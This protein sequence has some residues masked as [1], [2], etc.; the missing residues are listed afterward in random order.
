MKKYLLLAFFSLLLSFSACNY[1][2]SD[3][4]TGVTNIELNISNLKTLPDSL[5]YV[6][7][8]LSNSDSSI[9]VFESNAD[10]NGVIRVSTTNDFNGLHKA[11][12]F[13]ITVEKALAIPDSLPNSGSSVVLE[14]RFTLGSANLQVGIG[15]SISSSTGSFS[16]T[17]P[18]DTLDNDLS[19]VWFADSLMREGGPL[20]G[21]NLPVLN[22]GWFYEGIV[23][24]NNDT[25]ST[26][27][28]TD[29]DAADEF[30]GYSGTAAGLP[31]PGED[32]LFNPKPGFTFPLD[33]SNAQ[34]KILL[35]Y[36]SPLT[37]YLFELFEGTIP[38]GVQ[39]NTTHQL[40][41]IDA[42]VPTG[43]VSIKVDIVE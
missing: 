24:I 37:S 9:K 17:T 22:T 23:L 15:K 4:P 27:E 21:F 29:P 13:W 16:I 8:I 18:T 2:E 19:G 5:I 33:L 12:R 42:P 43:V 25:L 34:V 10:A 36:E 35:R 11:Q 1:F 3:N 28:F 32:F 40:Q 39:A 41:K 31:F 30:S 20:A 14:G 26:G 7:W 38:A 6:G